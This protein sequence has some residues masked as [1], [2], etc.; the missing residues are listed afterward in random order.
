A[1]AASADLP[2]PSVR[3]HSVTVEDPEDA[4][5]GIDQGRR[6]LMFLDASDIIREAQPWIGAVALDNPIIDH[7]LTVFRDHGAP[8][9][10][11][12][13]LTRDPEGDEAE[14]GD[15]DERP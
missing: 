15:G 12:P 4:A 10:P 8:E 3:Y 2:A 1:E 13:E 7:W 11:L 5:A 9:R 14:E 6:W